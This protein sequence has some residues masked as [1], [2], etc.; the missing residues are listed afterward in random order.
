MNF[1]TG[2]FKSA[3]RFLKPIGTFLKNDV[4][5]PLGSMFGGDMV[6][7]VGDSIKRTLKTKIQGWSSRD[8]QEELPDDIVVP[9]TQRPGGIPL[10]PRY[11]HSQV[12]GHFNQMRDNMR[13]VSPVGN[14]YDSTP[15]PT[16]VSYGGHTARH[17]QRYSRWDAENEDENYEEEMDEFP[18]RRY[19]APRSYVAPRSYGKRRNPYNVEF[20]E[21][22][23]EY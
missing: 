19:E 12:G 9:Q 15:L 21:D 1:I 10:F 14:Y 2:L 23:E 18:Q 16:P 8:Q 11:T 5:K 7:S 3:G 13:R 20:A 6:D 22:E 17:Q 4:L